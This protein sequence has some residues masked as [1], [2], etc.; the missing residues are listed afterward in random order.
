M[1]SSRFLCF[2]VIAIP[3][4]L[5][6][7]ALPSPPPLK[8]GPN[9]LAN[10]A[11]SSVEFEASTVVQLPSNAGYIITAAIE[12]PKG[13]QLPGVLDAKDVAHR[14]TT[15]RMG[16]IVRLSSTGKFL[17]GRRTC[18][19]PRG[20]SLR[21]AASPEGAIFVAGARL[22]GGSSES[23]LVLARYNLNGTEEYFRDDH[24]RGPKYAYRAIAVQGDKTILLAAT[25]GAGK[26]QGSLGGD[27]AE[28]GSI[29]LVSARQGN[30]SSEQRATI[31][32]SAKGTVEQE[33]MWGMTLL[34]DVAFILARRKVVVDGVYSTGDIVYR[35]P[36]AD[37]A[38]PPAAQAELPTLNG[39]RPK[40]GIGAGGV[41]VGQ[42][43]REGS[44][45][46][47]VLTRLDSTT[48]KPSNFAGS[49]TNKLAQ[50]IFSPSGGMERADTVLAKI[51]DAPPGAAVILSA[52]T[53]FGEMP[54]IPDEEGQFN[55]RPSVIEVSA[56]GN[57]S[58]TQ[59]ASSTRKLTAADALR[60][61]NDT[62]TL[63]TDTTDA[64][65]HALY[66]AVAAGPAAP[67]A[68]ERS[69]GEDVACIGMRSVVRG[70]GI[71]Q[72]IRARGLRRQRHPLRSIRTALRLENGRVHVLCLAKR[73]SRVCVTP[74]HIV[75]LHGVARY[76]RDVCKMIPCEEDMQE[77]VNFKSQCGDHIAVN[78]DLAISMHSA[79][80]DTLNS[81]KPA[82]RVAEDECAQQKSSWMYWMAST[83]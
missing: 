19:L 35:I 8:F 57:V 69:G 81:G 43:S 20:E 14:N 31:T 40:I 49:Q 12:S 10:F 77:V 47:L 30:G 62:L 52:Q 60:I 65:R 50:T 53:G 44:K 15:S 32:R 9:L 82:G 70:V 25:L 37:V 67:K 16:L 46:S 63:A 23:Y 11:N 64:G 45:S 21:A 27:G 17:W 74:G 34:V 68:G 2:L 33:K 18:A 79:D 22:V 1:Y 29:A 55:L 4:A 51:V 24:G 71:L 58:R 13:A 6:A 80:A 54:D 39:F 41:L 72:T 73:G 42:V 5:T 59:T 48:L 75:Y 3:I 28:L 36:V 83:L 26:L 7:S 78:E 56:G 66:L 61:G 38:R 76:M